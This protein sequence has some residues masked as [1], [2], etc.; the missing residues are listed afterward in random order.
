MLIQHPPYSNCNTEEVTEIPLS[1]SI[2]IQ[3]DT[4][5][6]A[7]AFP[8]TEPAWL[9]APPYKRNFSVNVVLPAS[10]CEIIAK[11]RRFLIS[12]ILLLYDNFYYPEA[13]RNWITR[14]LHLIFQLSI[15]NLSLLYVA[16]FFY[17][18]SNSTYY[19]I[20]PSFSQVYLLFLL[21]ISDYI[22]LRPVIFLF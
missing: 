18:R 19:R 21:H 15:F 1:F 2:S 10:G 14:K 4:A 13:F 5:C 20:K 11:V 12:S 22:L 7:V 16:W 3:S 8:L 6:F 9:I 17:F